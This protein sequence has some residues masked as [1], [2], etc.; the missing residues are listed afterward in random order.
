MIPLLIVDLWTD[1]QFART[2]FSHSAASVSRGCTS[3][4][5]HWAFLRL[6]FRLYACGAAR[7]LGCSV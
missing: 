6:G 1:V 3:G 5:G 7:V 2:S 4:S